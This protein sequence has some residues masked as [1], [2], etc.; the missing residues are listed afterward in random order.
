MIGKG[1]MSGVSLS[2][3][4]FR[5]ATRVDFMHGEGHTRFHLSVTAEEERER[6]TRRVE[7]A[8]GQKVNKLT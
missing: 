8:R 7:Q 2:Q 5:T 3:T 4:S 6:E 1:D